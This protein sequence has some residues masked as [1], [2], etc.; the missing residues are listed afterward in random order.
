MKSLLVILMGVLFGV[1][2]LIVGSGGK[3]VGERDKV[4]TRSTF[5]GLVDTLSSL[6]YFKQR[7]PSMAIAKLLW[8][9]ISISKKDSL[10]VFGPTQS[11]KTSRL[12]IP[13]I[14]QFGAG[15]AVISSVKTD[16]FEATCQDRARFGDVYVFDPFLIG[17]SGNCRFDPVALAGDPLSRRRL[18]TL[19][20]SNI[21]VAGGG[22][23]SKF[24]ATLASRLLESLLHAA[25]VGGHSLLDLMVWVEDGSFEEP[26]RLLGGEGERVSLSRLLALFTEDEKIISS[27][28]TTLEAYLEPFHMMRFSAKDELLNLATLDPSRDSM[29]IYLVAPPTRQVEAGQLFATLIS[30][31]FDKIYQNPEANRTLFVFDEAANL[32]PISNLDEVVSTIASFGGQIISIYQDFAQLT[33][34][35]HESAMSIVNNHRA[36]LFLGGISDPSTINLAS[37]ISGVN[38]Q[39]K[40]IRIKAGG[41]RGET[42]LPNGALRSLSPGYGLLVYGHRPAVVV[43]MLAK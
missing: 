36:K 5:E 43:R 10:C 2:Y 11:F 7:D 20:T 42:L 15:S 28:V 22:S 25:F 14:C 41:D 38:R 32:A 33:H 24:W 19:I 18:A 4:K 39:V 8:Q 17:G 27:T 29:T 26:R 31:I 16:L 9:K 6:S 3:R 12:A 23:D 34:R 1:A 13:A 40:S 30:T 37:Q 21:A 35:Y